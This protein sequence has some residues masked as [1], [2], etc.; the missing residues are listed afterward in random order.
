HFDGQKII[1]SMVQISGGATFH[2]QGVAAIC[3][4]K[5]QG[6][7]GPILT[8]NFDTLLYDAFKQNNI[9]FT[10]LTRHQRSDFHPARHPADTD[11]FAYH[12]T[13]YDYDLGSESYTRPATIFSRGLLRPFEEPEERYLLDVL[14]SRTVVFF[15]YSGG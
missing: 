15:G 6:L 2:S 4:L 10:L 3:A 5:R 13:L 7:V 9:R 12:G 1:S 14:T 8:P 11:I